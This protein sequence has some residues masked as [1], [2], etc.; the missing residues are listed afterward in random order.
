MFGVNSLSSPSFVGCSYLV[1]IL[2][3]YVYLTH[4]V[5]IIIIII[6]IIT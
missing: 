3:C 1:V 4:K 5:I 6:I 2:N